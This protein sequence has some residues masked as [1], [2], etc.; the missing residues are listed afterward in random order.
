MTFPCNIAGAAKPG[1]A[2][3]WAA[4]RLWPAIGIL[5]AAVPLAAADNPLLGDSPLQ[6][7]YPQFDLIRTEHFR[8]AYEAAMD[9]H[10][11][12]IEAI[13]AN[14][15]APTFENTFVALERSGLRLESV[16]RLF[17]GLNMAATT[18][19]LQAL[20]KEMAP[21][22]AAHN[23]AILL[24]HRL[25][26]RIEAV[27]AERETL[28]LDAESLRLVERYRDD[29]VRAGAKLAPA[30][31]SV[32]RTLN[33]EIA[34]LQTVFAQNVLKE[35]NASVVLVDNRA[36]LEGWSDAA[37]A[38]SAEAASAEGHAGK[39]LIR[40]VNTSG[41]PALATLENRALRERIQTA[42]LAR[43]S[44]GGGYDNRTTVSRLVRLRAERAQLLGYAS[45]AAYVLADQTAGSEA[46]VDALLGKLAPAA[47]ANARREAA[48]LQALL[49]RDVPGA[50]LASWDWL[51]YSEKVRAARYDFDEERLRPYFEAGRVLRDG[52]FYA[53]TRLYGITFKER[54]DLPRYH[55]DV[56]TF[57][58]FDADGT[59][60]ALLIVD[61]YARPSKQGGGWACSYVPQSGLLGTRPVVACHLN[62]P[63]P[64][65]SEPT[66]MTAME[67]RTAFH[68]FGHNLHQMFSA[69]R[70][71]RFSGTAVPRDFVEF[72]SQVNEMWMTQ[73]EVLAH[74]ARDWRTGELIP[75]ELVARMAASQQF[76]QGHRTT[77][78]LAATLLDLAW[79]G[80]APAE[81]PAADAVEAFE[82]AA[83]RRAGVDLAAVPPRY[84]TT[85][86]AHLFS[87]G[88]SAGYYSYIWA[89]VLDADT[90][91]WFERNGGLTRANGDKLRA[92][93]LSRGNSADVM[94]LYRSFRGGGPELRPLL[95]RRGLAPAGK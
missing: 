84:R 11:R 81:V 79:H 47:V 37:I 87:M 57:E 94:T 26:A 54:P 9:G 39:F 25:F 23:D 55:P 60:L 27:Y 8:P 10:L 78:Y 17:G 7:G 69:V 46:A 34:G 50:R 56:R 86:F 38:A 63:K 93:I 91:G 32:L 59:S 68:E 80:L 88:Y 13:V 83:F 43:C 12:E 20:E 62:I 58:V 45:H 70:Y 72:P 90:V 3:L 61:W 65:A 48:D 82:A 30:G 71:P 53:A 21:R 51:Y 66:L 64:P 24:D 35:T 1:A 89:E 42:S 19:E 28:G 52:V 2:C 36:E 22:L 4:W 15:A 33:A 92:T 18:P 67:V 6:F 75:P 74:Y 5:A 44:H 31:Q 76:D 73:P 49:E 14:P 85:Y 40:L 95:E 41:Q 16:D 77:E 29:F